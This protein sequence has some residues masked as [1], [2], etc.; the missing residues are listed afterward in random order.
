PTGT[1]PTRGA[2]RAIAV[3]G[4]SLL[5]CAALFEFA[6]G[7]QYLWR[8]VPRVA[9]DADAGFSRRVEPATRAIAAMSPAVELA[10]EP[11]KA[12]TDYADS[13]PETGDSPDTVTV[14]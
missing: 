5:G 11:P 9:R 6:V 1:A 8:A 12:K 4:Y 2:R 3:V 7:I 10:P 14:T 13:S